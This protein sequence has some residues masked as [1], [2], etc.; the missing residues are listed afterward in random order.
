MLFLSCSKVNKTKNEKEITNNTIHLT[1]GIPVDSDS[2][3]DYLIV[4]SQYALSYNKNK[5]VANWVSWELNKDWYGTAKRYNKFMPDPDLPEGFYKVKTSDYARSG[6]DRGHMVRSEERT[7]SEEDNMA[8]FYM[9][10]IL[11]QT[12]DLNQGVWL[13]FENYLEKLC[14]DEDRELF[15]IAGGIFHSDNKIN[16]LIA[17]PD[18]CFKIVIILE[19]GQSI[20][21]I[22]ENTQVIAVVMPNIEGVRH[23]EWEQYKTT[24]RRIESSTGYDFLT[25]VAKNIQ[26]VIENK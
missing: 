13:H 16:D 26:D 4:R 1:L 10:N 5:N 17:I 11:P 3:D 19:S 18:S 25:S 14:K 22:N 21:D 20:Q 2:S 9:T 8:T 12:P 24:I 23:D 15:I 7:R 6:Y